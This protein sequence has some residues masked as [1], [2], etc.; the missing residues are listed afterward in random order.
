VLDSAS[1]GVVRPDVLGT[2]RRGM[3]LETVRNYAAR[4]GV[5]Q[6]QFRQMLGAPVTPEIAGQAFLTLATGELGGAVAYSLTG[7]DGLI[8]L[9]PLE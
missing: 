8:P 5:S 4:E 2:I 3:S 1:T 7:D 6:E 9:P